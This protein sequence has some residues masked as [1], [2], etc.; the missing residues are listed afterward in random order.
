MKKTPFNEIHRE[1]G[2]KL[3]EFA[4]FEMP[5]QYSGIVNEHKTVRESVGVFDVSHMGEFFVHGKD[6]EA[7]LQ[8]NTLNDVTKLTPGRAQYTALVN[9]NGLLLDDLIVYKIENA[10]MIVANASNI[11]KDFKAFSSRITGDVKLEDA[12]DATALLSIQGPNST[13]TLGKITDVD[14]SAIQYYHFVEGKIAG[15][16]AIISRTGYTGEVG[17]EVFF[18]AKSD[19]C[20]EMWDAIFDAGKEFGI[21]PIGLGARDTLR[22]EMGY[23]LYGNDIDEST[24]PIEAGL[25][26]IT[27]IDKGDFFGKDAIV[28]AKQNITRK[29]VGFKMGENAIPR[30]GYGI[31]S[32]ADGVKTGIV[33]SGTF[34]PSLEVGI[35]MGYVETSLAAEN[36]EVFVDIRG[37]KAPARVVK[38]PFVAKKN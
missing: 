18:G 8:Q 15:I 32:S 11:E 13:A 22:L 17:F 30:H 37:K 26:W 12:S 31:Y 10:Y 16:D 9:E 20:A 33:T 2:A 36:R 14:L 34:S 29:L 6:A 1:L 25:G 38:L 19:D 23:C 21:L 7:F 24:N 28:R 3:V 4:G 27:K 5:V 35:G